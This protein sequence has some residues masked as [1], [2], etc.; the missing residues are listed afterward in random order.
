[1]RRSL[2]EH[3]PVRR[4]KPRRRAVRAPVLAALFFVLARGPALAQD[5]RVPAA[6][7]CLELLFPV[8]ARA[9]AL[10]QTLVAGGAGE[11]VY[12]NPA[13]LAWVTK[14]Q[15]L[16]HRGTGADFETTALSLLFAPRRV[17]TIGI[18][19]QLFDYGTQ[20]A[21]DINGIETGRLA[22]REQ[23]LTGSFGTELLRGLAAGVNFKVYQFRNDCS[24]V[25]GEF[26][27]F[28]GTTYELDLGL[29]YHGRSAR[30]LRAGVSLNNAGFSLQVINVDQDDPPPTRVRAG[31]S[32]EVLQ[33]FRPDTTL[34]L[35]V[36][37]Q[38]DLKLRARTEVIP[39]VGVELSVGRA[40]FLMAGYRGGEGLNTGLSVGVGFNY[41]R[42]EI[43]IAKAFASSTLDPEGEPLQITF[44][45]GF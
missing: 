17:G 34:A 43:A 8:G 10:G 42:F 14:G 1:M 35:W 20:A 38:A 45:V 44:G 37:A 13:S 36:T 4:S 33:H 12:A 15:F 29:Q 7:C 16:V 18:S 11:G 40:V 41:D 21:T 19:Y 3:G 39:S 9:V 27:K 6:E 22:T 5:D 25:C 32:Y 24:G 2:S 31:V 26:G 28:T 23:T 30:S